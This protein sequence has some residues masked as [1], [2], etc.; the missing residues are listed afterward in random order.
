[1]DR[2]QTKASEDP[3]VRPFQSRRRSDADVLHLW[4][5]G[6]LVDHPGTVAMSDPDVKIMRIVASLEERLGRYPTEDEVMTFIFGSDDERNAVWNK[7]IANGR[8]S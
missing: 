1:M 3:R 8:V 4:S 7:E 6:H 2:V 5:L